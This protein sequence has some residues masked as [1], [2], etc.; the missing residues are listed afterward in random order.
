VDADERLR[1]YAELAVRVGA[2]VQDGQPVGIWCQLEHAPIARA[3]ASEAYRAGASHVHVQYN[4]RYIRRAS[5]EH[6]PRETLGKTSQYVLDWIDALTEDGTAFI[7][8]TGDPNPT[9]FADLDQELVGASEPS[10]YRRSWLPHVVNRGVNWTIVSAPNEG[11]AATV[12]GEPDL[13]RLW[14]AV[15]V[16]TRLDQPDPVAAWRDHVARLKSRAAGLNERG[17]DALRFR[18]PGTDLTVGLL[19]QSR[20][21]CATF[22]RADGLEHLPNVPTEEVF[23]SP[24]WRRTEGVVRSTL[25]LAVGGTIVEDLQMR[26]EAGRVADVSASSGL[27]VIEH[28]LATDDQ[29][30]FLGEVALVDGTSAVKRT[31]LVFK[32]TLFDENAACHIAYGNGLPMCVEG[33]DGLGRDELLELGVNV[34]GEHTDFMIGGPEV[35][36]DGLTPDGE[37]VAIIRDDAWRLDA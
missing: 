3:I 22:E 6:G 14:E 33:A 16:A 34:S 4:D 2:N 5:I 9:L 37:A 28:Q 26:F 25:P 23:T 36:V 15:A 18:G 8:L 10:D 30:R 12:F 21:L 29:A 19:P 13:E 7:Q 32:D 11:W 20:F 17:F 1:R 31:G 27:A 35:E 24:D